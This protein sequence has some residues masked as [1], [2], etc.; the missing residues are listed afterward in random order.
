MLPRGFAR[1]PLNGLLE[2][3]ACAER[4]YFR[5]R[6]PHFLLGLRIDT[7]PG[8]L[9]TD[10]ELAEASNLNFLPALEHLRYGIRKGLEVPLGLA[11]GQLGSLGYLL[12]Q[13][14]LIH[15][16]SSPSLSLVYKD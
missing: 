10:V 1:L 5:S 12:D 4:G 7:L 11:L 14:C 15:R 9:L 2:A 3:F 16:S 8:L 6:N 13:L